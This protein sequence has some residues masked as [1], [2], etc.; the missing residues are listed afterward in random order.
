M[1]RSAEIKWNCLEVALP[2]LIQ[3][4]RAVTASAFKEA[5]ILNASTDAGR[6]ALVVSKEYQAVVVAM[7]HRDTPAI[8]SALSAFAHQNLTKETRVFALN[9][10]KGLARK[11]NG[12]SALTEVSGYLAPLLE[13]HEVKELSSLMLEMSSVAGSKGAYTEGVYLV[14]HALRMLPEHER[15]A[16]EPH[17]FMSLTALIHHRLK[18]FSKPSVVQYAVDGAN[19]HKEFC[20]AFAELTS[21]VSIRCLTD[22]AGQFRKAGS[23]LL[24]PQYSAFRMKAPDFFKTAGELSKENPRRRRNMARKM[25]TIARSWLGP[26][27]PL[28]NI[29]QV[30]LDASHLL[31]GRERLSCL[32]L[33]FEVADAHVA[34]GDYTVL[35][36][37]LDDAHRLADR[38][39]KAAEFAAKRRGPSA[40][41]KLM[42][43]AVYFQDYLELTRA[44]TKALASK[45]LLVMKLDGAY[46]PEEKKSVLA[47]IW[48]GLNEA[49]YPYVEGGSLVTALRVRQKNRAADEA[50]FAARQDK[51]AHKHITSV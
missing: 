32:D 26:Y 33:M 36:I 17:A 15:P 10:L 9:S 4:T 28:Q 37:V 25:L 23:E 29:H 2:Y 12:F 39:L 45:S 18:N 46:P 13:P 16:A 41:L 3:G 14:K 44:F 21:L 43:D 42:Q 47:H 49:A 5:P 7:K 19:D 20:G 22:L 51:K 38:T 31:R 6:Q 8:Q 27:A 35:P 40:Q 30:S 1:S 50:A 34:R 24:R 11:E 48:Q